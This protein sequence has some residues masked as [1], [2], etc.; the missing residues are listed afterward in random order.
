MCILL[1]SLRQHPRYPLIVAANREETYDRPTAAASFWDDAPNVLAGRDLL[2]G[3]TWL[4]ITRQGRFAALTN[5]RRRE[6]DRPDGPSRGGLVSEFLRGNQTPDDYLA[7]VV[8]NGRLY[9][10]FSLIVGDDSEFRYYSNQEHEPHQL[11]SSLYGVSNHLLDTP[12]PKLVQGKRE[13]NRLLLAASDPTPDQL[14]TILAN[15]TM[16]DDDELPDT[17]IGID[18]ERLLS[19]LFVNAGNYGTRSSTVVLIDK[20]GNVTLVERTFDRRPDHYSTVSH[21]F[22]VE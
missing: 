11:V 20:T 12:W 10:G 3:G 16:A 19:P 18:N 15:S 2:Q 5:F 14:F 22:V 4:G 7:E 13:L 8:A 1:L 9:S 21:Q 17:G 6:S